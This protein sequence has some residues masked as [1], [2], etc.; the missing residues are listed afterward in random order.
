MKTWQRFLAVF[1]ALAI[2]VGITFA[3]HSSSS[4]KNQGVTQSYLF[5]DEFNGTTLDLS[6]WQPNWYGANNTSPSKPVNG[7]ERACYDPAQVSES[8]GVANLTLVNKTCSANGSTYSESTGAISTLHT[9]TFTNGTLRARVYLPGSTTALYNW[10]AV[11]TDG[12]GTW[13]HTG[14]SDILEGLGGKGCFHYHSDAGGPGGCVTMA[15]GWH[16]LAEIV[17]NG[18]VTYKYDRKVVGTEK[19]VDA[20]HF[21][22]IG[23]QDG[24]YG[25]QQVLP[26]TMKIDWIRVSSKV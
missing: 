23:N 24:S 15:G 18:T 26:T 11:W 22:I 6:K 16:T 21:I 5:Q 8:A 3:V 12:T 1:A 20:P 9:F 4:N 25:G 2:V 17:N 10:P 19:T 7:A 14:E 13:P